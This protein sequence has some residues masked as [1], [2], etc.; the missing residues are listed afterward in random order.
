MLCRGGGEG[1]GGEGGSE[2]VSCR[3]FALKPIQRTMSLG[4]TCT[5]RIRGYRCEG[6]EFGY[7]AISIAPSGSLMEMYSWAHRSYKM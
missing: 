7:A 6:S 1:R 5:M 3:S 2:G 4:M